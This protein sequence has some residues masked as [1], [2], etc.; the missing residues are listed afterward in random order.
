MALH[1]DVC[2]PAILRS[3]AGEAAAKA[4]LTDAAMPFLRLQ[5]YGSGGY[6]SAKLKSYSFFPF[7]QSFH[8]RN[9]ASQVIGMVRRARLY[10][11]RA[12]QPAAKS[13]S[14]RAVPR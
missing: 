2:G 3:K 8:V 5:V 4:A 1:L 10:M 11:L 9:T 12:Q 7:I 13:R 14:A 6:R